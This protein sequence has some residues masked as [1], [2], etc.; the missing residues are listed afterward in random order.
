[1]PGPRVAYLTL[2]YPAVSH[3]FI[4]REVRALR[5]LG[6]EIDTFSIWTTPQ[7]QLLSQADREEGAATFN[8]LPLRAGELVRSQLAA[9][10]ASPRA[11]A[12]LVGRA[13]RVAPP[14]LRGRFLAA[15]WVVEA[16]ILWRQLRRRGI[17]HVHAHLN[18]TAPAVAMLATEFANRMEGRDRHTW[19]MTVHGPYELY[20]VE[21][22][23]LPQKVRSADFTACVSDYTRSQLMAFVEERHWG[24]LKIVHDAVLPN[25]HRPARAADNG[26]PVSL[27][28][29]ARLAPIKGHAVLL[30]ALADLRARGVEARL[31]IVGDG[32]KRDDLE[33]LAR[34]RGIEDAVTF[35]GPVG[36]DDIA[37]H[38]EAA[39]VFVHPS[40]GEGIPL[41]L[42]EAMAHRL[43]VVAAAVHGVGELVVDGENG[44]L[45]RPGRPDELASGVERLAADPDLRRRMGGHGRQ[46]VEREFDVEG[47]AARLR[48]MFARCADR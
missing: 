43:P 46:A 22:E 4:L 31:V 40:F 44:L 20:D 9:L 27:L 38:F 28:S 23:A 15:S 13:L 3:T 10:A 19:S 12:W 37:A 48:D 35:A 2:R 41:V 18:G 34:R 21:N 11:Y 14:G 33:E 32:P 7:D 30:E 24:K 45:V 6:L 25:A 5:R 36:Q 1:V 26:A 39:D 47:S 17:R 42:M 16:L 29:V 8:I